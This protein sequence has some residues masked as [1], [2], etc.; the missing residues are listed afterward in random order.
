[1]GKFQLLIVHNQNKW[2]VE[3]REGC[4]TLFKFSGTSNERQAREIG[5]AFVEGIFYMRGE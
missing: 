5:R 3:V 2:D 4:R 1:M